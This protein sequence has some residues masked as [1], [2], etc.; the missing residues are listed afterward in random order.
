[1]PIPAPLLVVTDRH[2]A[3]LPLE[4]L[5]EKALAAGARWIWLRDRDLDL[6]KR[7]SLA[8][9]LR[10]QTRD[11]SAYLSIGADAELAAEVSADG[12]H[13]PA[14]A[15]IAAARKRLGEGALIGVS[16]HRIADAEAAASAGADYVT[17]SPIFASASK[18]GYGPTLG[19]RA[20]REAARA[21]IPIIALGGITAASAGECFAAGAAGVAAMGEIMRAG[22]T[23]A[24]VT[25]ILAA[26]ASVG[27]PRNR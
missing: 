9:A 8:L 6:A 12:V 11:A 21:G 25:E 20:I 4:F 23:A 1:M 5:T 27:G 24:V 26:V 14:K 17:L 10:A 3:I 22:G 18:P 7:R 15:D 13:L 19:A 16:A 2:Q